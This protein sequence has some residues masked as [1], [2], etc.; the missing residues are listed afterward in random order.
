[1]PFA[2]I[3][4]DN[5]AF[6]LVVQAING[7]TQ[8]TGVAPT[9]GWTQQFDAFSTTTSREAGVFCQTYDS[10][11]T[12]SN[13]AGGDTTLTHS[14]YGYAWTFAIAPPGSSPQ[15]MS[16]SAIASA[17]AFGTSAISTTISLSPGGVSSAESFGTTSLSSSISL[18]PSGVGSAESVSSPAVD[19]PITASPSGVTTAES[20]SSPS[21]D[22]PI[23]ASPSA[24]DSAETFGTASE[25]LRL[26]LS[27]L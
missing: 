21:V 10:N 23:T 15:T 12:A 17:E 2:A 1:M 19:I 4:P 6:M 11:P 20:V 9:T 26:S 22:I 24:V 8:I 14:G 16:P 18:L 25:N 3:D 13:V 27:L 5:E 7:V